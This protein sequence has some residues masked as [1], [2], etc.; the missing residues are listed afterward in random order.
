M[1]EPRDPIGK[2]VLRVAYESSAPHTGPEIWVRQEEAMEVR[3]IYPSWALGVE[4][5]GVESVFPGGEKEDV[6]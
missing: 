6:R 5:D 1:R 4:I 2:I 3:I